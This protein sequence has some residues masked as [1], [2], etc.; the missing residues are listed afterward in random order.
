M[1]NL[2]TEMLVGCFGFWIT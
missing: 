1:W 2:G